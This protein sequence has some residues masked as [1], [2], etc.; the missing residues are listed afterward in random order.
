MPDSD[1]I[2]LTGEHPHE[3]TFFNPLVSALDSA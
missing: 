3:F 2:A 1:E